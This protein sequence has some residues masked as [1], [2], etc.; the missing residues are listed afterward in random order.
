MI[1]LSISENKKVK[2]YRI[3]EMAALC[4]RTNK[5][6]YKLIDRGIMPDANFRTPNRIIEKGH[7]RGSEML[8][9]RLYS[10]DYL[11]PKLIEIFKTVKQG[12]TITIETKQ[13][14]WEAFSYEREKLI[15]K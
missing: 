12:R 13:A 9:E 4:G 14:L 8:G 15:K 5:A 3:S 2:F 6:F 10:V 11:A 7:L 1:E